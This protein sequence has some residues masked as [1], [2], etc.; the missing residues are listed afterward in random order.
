MVERENST[1]GLVTENVDP[2]LWSSKIKRKT[3]GFDAYCS[4]IL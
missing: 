1:A 2:V 3:E 4:H